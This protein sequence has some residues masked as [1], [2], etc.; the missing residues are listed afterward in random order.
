MR[1]QGSLETQMKEE[2]LIGEEEVT[3]AMRRGQRN[4]QWHNHTA[5]VSVC[6]ALLKEVSLG[7]IRT[8]ANARPTGFFFVSLFL[9]DSL[10]LSTYCVL[11]SPSLSLFLW[12][13]TPSVT[14]P[15]NRGHCPT[16]VSASIT[17]TKRNDER[18]RPISCCL[19]PNCINFPFFL[20]LFLKGKMTEVQ[21]SRFLIVKAE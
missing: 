15:C 14:L 3:T 9:I 19:N 12:G 13:G 1:G 18:Q 20:F 2:T 21:M 16:C 8:A 6:A 4:E 17:E 7:L 10:S 11:I 5:A